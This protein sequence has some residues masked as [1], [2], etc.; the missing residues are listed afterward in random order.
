MRQREM[1]AISIFAAVLIFFC[2][3]ASLASAQEVIRLGADNSINK[4]KNTSNISAENNSKPI[5]SPQEY[6]N[7][8]LGIG[9][10]LLNVGKFDIATGAFTVDFYLSIKCPEGCTGQEFEFMNGRASSLE[11]II[12]MPNEKFY[13]IQA[14]LSS[15]VDLKRFPFYTQK[16]QIIL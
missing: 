5:N 14:Q 12:D 8:K 9:L 3:G 6:G 10:Y 13:R 7:D 11:K 1:R 2:L 16:I 4:I 15:P